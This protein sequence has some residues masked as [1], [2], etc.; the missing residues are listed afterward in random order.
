LR[1]LPTVVPPFKGVFV[2]TASPRHFEN[3]DITAWGA[4]FSRVEEV[5][6]VEPGFVAAGGEVKWIVEMVPVWDDRGILKTYP[7]IWE[8]YLDSGGRLLHD[9]NGD[10]VYETATLVEPDLANAVDG[11]QRWEALKESVMKLALPFFY[12]F[13]FCHCRNVELKQQ[14]VSRQVR[15]Q[16]ERKGLPLLDY[17]VLEIEPMKKALKSEGGIEEVGPRKALHICRGHFKTYTVDAPLFGQHAG[18]WWWEG[19]L[20][21]ALKRGDNQ[22]DYKAKSPQG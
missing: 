20:R 19:Q 21:S 7:C 16:A 4:L 9:D 12:A 10:I 11:N 18:T 15:R 3:P 6:V 5:E 2:E 17:R 22:E 14:D 13:A 1:D 8:F